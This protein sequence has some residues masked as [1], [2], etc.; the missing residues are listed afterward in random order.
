MATAEPREQRREL[1]AGLQLPPVS[2]PDVPDLPSRPELLPV[3]LNEMDLKVPALELV[4]APHDT[5]ACTELRLCCAQMPREFDEPSQ[6]IIDLGRRIRF[7]LGP[8]LTTHKNGDLDF[9]GFSPID[10]RVYCY[11][12]LAVTQGLHC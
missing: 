7:R 12:R 11:C 3:Q 8:I 2:I 1:P 9:W 4:A 10:V 6:Y 5:Q